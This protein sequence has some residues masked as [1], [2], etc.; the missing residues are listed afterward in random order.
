MAALAVLLA[1]EPRR[2]EPMVDLRF[3]RSVPFAGANLSAVCAIAVMA[4]FPILSTLYLQDVRG[5]SA[6]QAGLDDP[7]DAGG[8]GAV[9]TGKP[10][11]WSPNGTHGPR[12]TSR[13]PR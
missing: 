2:A 6:L 4:G 12:V 1:Y 8:D 9:R 13:G 3:F 7:A 10:A 5:L 11:V